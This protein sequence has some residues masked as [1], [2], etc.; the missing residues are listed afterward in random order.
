[1]NEMAVNIPEMSSGPRVAT[2]LPFL[3]LKTS[4]SEGTVDHQHHHLITGVTL[5]IVQRHYLQVPPGCGYILP[6][7]SERR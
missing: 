4:T 1:M 3:P 2:C 7:S 5:K 6:S